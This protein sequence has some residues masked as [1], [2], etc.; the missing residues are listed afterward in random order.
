MDN[1]RNKLLGL[2]LAEIFGKSGED[3]DAYAK[4]VVAADFDEPG[5]EDVLRKVMADIESHGV[6]VSEHR[7]RKQLEELTVEA[8]RQIMEE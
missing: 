3:A 2:W 4:E 1:R 7:V 6:D 8:K 5:Y